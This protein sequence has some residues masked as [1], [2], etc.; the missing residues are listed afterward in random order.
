MSP[1]SKTTFKDWQKEQLK[2]PEFAAIARELEPGYQISRLRIA[3]GLTQA[4]LAEMVGT[5]QPS[6]ARIES[7]KSLPS[8]LCLERVASVLNARVEVRILPM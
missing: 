4:Q 8:L 7:G 6:I 2:N 3:Q 5:H 1:I